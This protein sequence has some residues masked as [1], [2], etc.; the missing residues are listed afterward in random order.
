MAKKSTAPRP[1]RP[2]AQADN[3]LYTV[4]L[5]IGLVTVLGT[6]GF[7]IYRCVELFDAPFPGFM[8]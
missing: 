1:R 7:V 5:S 4:L 3:D 2:Q 6:I 8:S